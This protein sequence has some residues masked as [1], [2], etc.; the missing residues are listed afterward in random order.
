[1]SGVAATFA[2]QP[3][4]RLKWITQTTEGTAT[5]SYV[6][7]MQETWARQGMRG[8]FSGSMAAIYRNVPH[9]TLTY[10]IY[11]HAET[12]TLGLQGALF[13]KHD[14]E[15]KATFWTRFW[16]GWGTLFVAT[17]FT[18]PLDTLRV[19]MSVHI[20][21]AKAGALKSAHAMYQKEGISSF[22][23]GFLP[24]LVGAGPRGAFGFGIFE[25]LKPICRQNEYLQSRPTL[26]KFLCGYLAGVV[27]EF[28]IYPLDTIRRRQQALGDKSKIARSGIG[29]ALFSI[30][31]SEGFLGLFKGLPL[32]LIKNPVATAVSFAVNDLVKEGLGH[33]SG[34]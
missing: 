3:V 26:S 34:T 31:R 6:S 14:R 33:S 13:R 28:F 27:S 1:M 5:R 23:Y 29:S 7:V 8:F 9:S 20:D 10:T 19:R 17:V 21:S 11:P 24:T 25:T 2:K 18:H 4:Q 12:L 30:A 15:N 16:A 22:Y 32:N